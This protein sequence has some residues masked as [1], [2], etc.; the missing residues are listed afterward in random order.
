MFLTWG[1]V[2]NLER[3]KGRLYQNCEQLFLGPPKQPGCAGPQ[4]PGG[5]FWL[6]L[7][8]K[9]N[10]RRFKSRRTGKVM[11]LFDRN[12]P[13]LLTLVKQA[14]PNHLNKSGFLCD[15]W[16]PH[17]CHLL[18]SFTPS[19]GIL[20]LLQRDL[21]VIK[22]NT[23]TKR[24]MNTIRTLGLPHALEYIQ[25]QPGRICYVAQ[26]TILNICNNP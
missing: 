23:H 19:T 16:T 22:M 24:K 11:S 26:G 13:R 2:R 20:P 8:V 25:K 21:L 9:K 18:H 14:S 15:L 17:L 6:P 1:R 5:R 3:P 10:A 7:E 4:R 12:K